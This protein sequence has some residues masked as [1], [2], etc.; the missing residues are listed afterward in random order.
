MFVLAI[1]LRVILE[2]AGWLPLVAVV[3]IA[4]VV[5]KR[6]GTSAVMGSAKRAGEEAVQY[7][8]RKREQ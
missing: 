4:V 5:A 2:F 6:R 7:L 3:V 1:A 8:R